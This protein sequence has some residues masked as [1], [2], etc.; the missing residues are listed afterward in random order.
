MKK[1]NGYLI[2]KFNAR[3]VREWEGTALGNYGVIDAELYTGTLEVDRSVMEYD[4]AETLE[5]AIE[6]ARGLESELDVKE[7]DV[8]ITVIK[9]T[10]ETTGE[11]EFD[12]EA[13]FNHE[14]AVLERHIKSKSYP[15]TDPR[16][17]AHALYGYARALKQLG[18]VDDF[19]E[20]FFISPDIFGSYD[21]PQ[22]LPREPE[23]LLAHICDVVCKERIPGRTQEELDAVCAKCAVE[24]LA[25]EGDERDLRV[26][27]E[28]H[29]GLNAIINKLRG[30]PPGTK[31]ER[32]E[33]E[34]RAYLRALEASGTVTAAESTAFAAAIE[35]AVEAGHA[36]PPREKFLNLGRTQD[37][38]VY[39]LGLLLAKDCPD[40]D[41]RVYLNIFR[42]AQELDTALD[43]AQGYAA[44][45]LRREL[46]KNFRELREMY[47]GNYAIQ[48]YKEAVQP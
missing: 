5:E 19:D 14:K 24:R 7:P 13:L 41:C 6:K 31:A 3:E 45:T 28:A 10:N 44:D 30:T 34:A 22:P 9:E 21:V 11:E 37:R 48:K 35:E 39:G 20:R 18:M 15:D 1:I 36:A 33:Y 8:K 32:L 4:D 27:A 23:E 29:Q 42:M 43:T 17:A 38:K 12:P 26:R 2:V 16:T 25:N 46:H 40:N 47:L